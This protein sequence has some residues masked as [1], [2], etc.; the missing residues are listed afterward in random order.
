MILPLV[1]ALSAAA[2]ALPPAPTLAEAASG[3][4]RGLGTEPFWALEISPRTLTL[5]MP[6]ETGEVVTE[7]QVEYATAL[8]ENRVVTAGALIVTLSPATCSDGMSDT[9]YP[10]TLE[11]ALAGDDMLSLKGCA[12]RPW[13]QDVIAALPVIDACLKASGHEPPVVFAAATAPDAGFVMLAGGDQDPL[14]ACTVAAG[15]ARIAPYTADAGP[16]GTNAEIFIRGPGENPG[17]ECYQAP[18][19]TDADGKLV[20]WWLDPLGC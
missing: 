19:V 13:G 9:E 20:G 10:Y 5:T 1:L 2:P 16:A 14:H 12:Y 3:T 18:E 7:F 8:G 17:G 4:L 11:A 15:A 6:G